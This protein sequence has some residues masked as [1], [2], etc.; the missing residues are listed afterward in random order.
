MALIKAENL[1]LGYEGH[2]IVE[3]LNFTVNSGDYLCIIGE[4]GSGKST[5]MKTL[6]GLKSKMGGSLTFGDGLKKNQI[7][8]V[9]VG[10]GSTVVG[11]IPNADVSILKSASKIYLYTE[12]RDDEYVSVPAVVGMSIKEANLLLTNLGLNIAIN[13]G[14]SEKCTTMTVTSQSLPF[15]AKVKKGS[16]V[17]LTVLGTDFED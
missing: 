2:V 10:N 9:L 3:D 4:N 6:L 14:L 8:Y 7:N 12:K 11:Q 13:G 16:V 15:G 1:A 17:T 5:L